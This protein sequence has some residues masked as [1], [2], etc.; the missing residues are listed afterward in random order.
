MPP[1]QVLQ[2]P[3]PVRSSALVQ[4]PGVSPSIH[5]RTVLGYP[6]PSDGA[7]QDDGPGSPPSWRVN[8]SVSVSSRLGTA[9]P[10]RPRIPPLQFTDSCGLPL[11]TPPSDPPRL[12]RP[13]PRSAASASSSGRLGDLR[14]TLSSSARRMTPSPATPV[15]ATNFPSDALVWVGLPPS[16]L[17]TAFAPPCPAGA[18]HL[19]PGS[20]DTQKRNARRQ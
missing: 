10:L 2:R 3:H 1:R 12:A 16:Q 7:N 6:R 13:S 17:S 9:A 15:P 8:R 19:H 20:A 14:D 11:P 5:K 18:R 4:P